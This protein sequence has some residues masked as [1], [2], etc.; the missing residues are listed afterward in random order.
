MNTAEF[1]HELYSGCPNGYLEV[2]SLAPEGVKLYPRTV[3]QWAELPLGQIDFASG[4][5]YQLNRKGYGCY[6]GL[7]VRR[8]KKAPEQRISEKTGKPY[9]YYQRGKQHDALYLPALYVDI[10][11]PSEDAMWRIYELCPPSM[12]VNTGGGWHGYWILVEP[13]EIDDTNRHEIKRTLKGMAVACGGDTKVAELAR[14][15]RMPGT[16]NTKPD[17]GGV[18][19]HVVEDFGYP[20]ARFHFRDFQRRFAHLGGARELRIDRPIPIEASQG[21]PKWVHQYLENGAPVGDRNNRL[22]AVAREYKSN[23]VDMSQCLCEAGARARADGLH[24]EEIERTVHSAYE[25]QG[26]V[27]IDPQFKAR[28]AAQDAI[29]RARRNGGAA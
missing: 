28:I 14:V 19:A 23:G 29:R 6:F 21:L 18:V 1:L 20:D 8:E 22:Y 4:D 5:A 17:R 15:L 25:A 9:T 7:C 13:L 2:T 16:V 12:I 26:V 24:D 11:D 10:D 27:N 3:V